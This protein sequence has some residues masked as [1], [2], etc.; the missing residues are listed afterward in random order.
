MKLFEGPDAEKIAKELERLFEQSKRLKPE[1]V[2]KGSFETY[3]IGL[4]KKPSDK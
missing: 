3:F 2:R 4:R 1:A